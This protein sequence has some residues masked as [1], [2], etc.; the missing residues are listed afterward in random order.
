MR[1]SG[2]VIIQ[3]VQKMWIFRLLTSEIFPGIYPCDP[4]VQVAWNL[5]KAG[6]A[7]SAGVRHRPGCW[8]WVFFVAKRV[9]L[10][11]TLSIMNESMDRLGGGFEYFVSS[12]WKLEKWSNLINMFRWVGS[13]TQLAGHVAFGVVWGCFLDNNK[14]IAWWQ[15]CHTQAGWKY[16]ARWQVFSID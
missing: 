7:F 3:Q 4:W 16:L 12:P 13:T 2:R 5:W 14:D 6:N 8:T 1:V 15:Q 10:Q 9:L 11:E